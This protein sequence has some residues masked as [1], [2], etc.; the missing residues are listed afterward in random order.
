VKIGQEYHVIDESEFD[1]CLLF[2]IAAD[3]CSN[4][5]C[6]N[7]A[8]CLVDPVDGRDYFCLCPA[9]FEGRNCEL[10]PTK[11]PAAGTVD[12]ELLCF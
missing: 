5:P 6:L 4:Q 2:G 12:F 7:G 3:P 10:M 8:T 1:A 9:K 11:A